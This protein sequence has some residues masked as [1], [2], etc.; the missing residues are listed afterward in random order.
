ME[1]QENNLKSRE[2]L[3]KM[4][5]DMIDAHL[6][7]MGSIRSGASKEEVR[8]NARDYFRKRD[9]LMEASRSILFNA[10]MTEK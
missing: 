3:A 8:D 1:Y 7:Y 10:K 9:E 5:M 6:C 4:A 2:E